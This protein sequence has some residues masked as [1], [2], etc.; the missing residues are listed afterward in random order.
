MLSLHKIFMILPLFRLQFQK[1]FRLNLPH[2]SLVSGKSHIICTVLQHHFNLHIGKKGIFSS[3]RATAPETKGVDM[4]VP[5]FIR[6]PPFDEQEMI[7]FPGATRSGLH[8]HS[9]VGPLPETPSVPTS[10][11]LEPTVMIFLL[12]PGAVMLPGSGP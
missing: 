7:R 5:L 8:I 11:S 2:P 10:M 12:L 1:P 9:N 3:A 6:Y 4:E